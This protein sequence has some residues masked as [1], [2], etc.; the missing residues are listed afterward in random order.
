MFNKRSPAKAKKINWA[1]YRAAILAIAGVTKE[2]E[3]IPSPLDP[4]VHLAVTKSVAR[5]AMESGM[6]QRHLDEDYFE[7]TELRFP[8]DM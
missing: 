1:M 6:A 8:L 3:L 2:G 5:A 7:D 4:K